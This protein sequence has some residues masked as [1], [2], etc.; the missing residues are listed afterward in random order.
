MYVRWRPKASANGS[1]RE[2]AFGT[3][4]RPWTGYFM[5]LEDAPGSRSPVRINEPHFN[6]FSE[7]RN[8]SYADRYDILC[9][10]LV[11]ERLYDAACLLLSDRDEGM[12][13]EYSELSEEISF[14]NFAT[15]LMSHALAFA[16]MHGA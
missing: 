10:K 12:Q 1:Y 2:G 5:L 15:S 16:K 6:V 7:F 8:S 11:R 4:S 3:S 14:R 9:R 13:G